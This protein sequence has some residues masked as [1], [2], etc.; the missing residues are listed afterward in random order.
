MNS[1][2]TGTGRVP[3]RWRSRCCCCCWCPSW[4]SSTSRTAS[5]GRGGDEEIPDLSECGAGDRPAVPV[6][7]DLLDDRLLV[8]QFAPGHRVG[9]GELPDGQVVHRAVQGPAGTAGG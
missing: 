8:Q 9:C 6:S 7:A 2:A 3:A 5:C 1:S 4:S